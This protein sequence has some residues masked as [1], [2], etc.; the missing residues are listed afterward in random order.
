MCE[1][2]N[3]FFTFQ[4]YSK[5]MKLIPK[6]NRFSFMKGQTCSFILTKLFI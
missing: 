5:G 6:Y 4:I 1:L 2:R 3:F